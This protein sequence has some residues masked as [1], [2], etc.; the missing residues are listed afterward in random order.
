LD[1]G[2]HVGLIIRT[3][4][5]RSLAEFSGAFL[6]FWFYINSVI[7]TIIFKE[8]FLVLQKWIPQFLMKLM[9]NI[10][11][12]GKNLSIL[13]VFIPIR[14]MKERAAYETSI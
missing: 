12:V 1:V 9:S 5:N 7:E 13:Y 2:I 4:N 10:S 8:F 6:L 14:K 11:E 3:N